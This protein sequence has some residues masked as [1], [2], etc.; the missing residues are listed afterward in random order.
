[1]YDYYSNTILTDT[2]K[3]QTTQ[4]L[5]RAQ[6]RL[7]QHLLYRGLKPTDL[8]IDNKCPDALQRVFRENSVD[9][10]ICPPNNN[11]TNKSEKAI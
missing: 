5:M 1:M 2:L 11:H 9:L 7:I 6:T 8:R 4:E 3:K 10:Q